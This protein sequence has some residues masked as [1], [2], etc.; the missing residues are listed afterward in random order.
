MPE[1]KTE[2]RLLTRLEAWRPWLLLAVAVLLGG[3]LLTTLQGLT[4]EIQY[5]AVLQAITA[6]PTNAIIWG[7]LAT[8]LSY[9]GLMG[10]DY[11]SLKLVGARVPVV[12]VAQ[13]SFMGYA[14]GN[15]VGL[16][17]L[18]GGAVRMRMFMAAGAE[19]GQVT[20]AIIIN[21]LGFG[22]GTGCLGALGLIW[23]AG[24]A[25][26]VLHAPQ[27]FLEIL[28][29]LFVGALSLW[30]LASNLGWKPKLGGRCLDF[31]PGNIAVLGLFTVSVLDIGASGAVLWIL[32][33]ADTVPFI[34]FVT[35][36]A[37][38]VMIGVASH[39]PGGLGVFEALMLL[40]LHGRVSTEALAGALLLFRVIYY[41]VPLALALA[42]LVIRELFQGRIAPVGRALISL[43][44]NMLAAFT[45]VIGVMLMLS[46]VL[47]PTLEAAD[48]LALK[49][50]LPIV[51]ASHFLGSV[52]G[53]AMIFV[54]RAMLLRLDA[55]WWAGLFLAIVS[56][57]LAIPKGIAVS[58]AAVLLFFTFALAASRKQFTRRASLLALAFSTEWLVA[59]AVIIAALTWLLFFVYRDVRYANELWWQF[60]FNGDAPRSLRALMAV[61]LLAM[62]L[63]FR[64]LFRP[65]S[66]PFAEATPA[67]LALARRILK[68]QPISD[69]GLA[70]MGDKHFLFSK[71]GQSFLMFGRRGRTWVALY[72]PI[73]PA[74]DRAE[75]I[76]QFLDLARDQ[77]GRAAFYQARPENLA[78]YV[79]AG[80]SIYKLG[81]AAFVPLRNFTLAGSKQ[82]KL[83]SCMN[84]AQRDGL[85]LRIIPHEQICD[86]L[87]KLKVI[88]DAWLNEHSTAEKGFSLGSFSLDYLLQHD[89]AVVTQGER[90]VAFATLMTTD[91]NQEASVDL[92]RQL[93]GAPYGTMDFLFVELMLHYSRAN[94]ERFGLGMA[95][96]SG[97]ATNPFAPRWHKFGRLLFSQGE[98][99]YNFQGLRAFKDKFNPEWTPR[100]LA[101]PNGF[102][103]LIVLTDTAALISGGIKGVLTK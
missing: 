40:S 22:L 100:Y 93:P 62:A 49:V 84:R 33:P 77:G 56:L 86:C 85:A 30:I 1:P 101:C 53:I 64:Q 6:T 51:E 9:V 54:A 55:A 21:A 78:L 42:L 38:A 71:S 18:T 60:A 17:M 35:F 24:P 26:E 70:L 74:S 58:E 19:A 12:I 88:S 32:L 8:G 98:H 25:A 67:D 102:T 45:L 31:F 41:L 3:L 34:P 5:A 97:L 72:D 28:A 11:I 103:P 50:P 47:P 61:V 48:L 99:F 76:W 83:R 63:A 66:L 23:Q 59:L 4:R 13:T 29:S 15:T 92:I 65:P 36:F 68:Q 91:L 37:I 14:L 2:P 52:A 80:L 44:P 87:P 75:L 82:A 16:G 96:M 69:A 7:L 57:V 10:Y 20:R 39:V 90:W 46:G 81:E 27:L 94:F 89:V 95:P 79:D 43:A 73:G